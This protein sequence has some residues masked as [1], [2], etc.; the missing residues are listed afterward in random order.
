MVFSRPATGIGDRQAHDG[1]SPPSGPVR[2]RRARRGNPG[3]FFGRAGAI[4]SL[5]ISLCSRFGI[6]ML[7]HRL[8]TAIALEQALGLLLAGIAP[9]V[10]GM[11]SETAKSGAP[12][13]CPGP[14]PVVSLRGDRRVERW[15]WT[16]L[17]KQRNQGVRQY[18]GGADPLRVKGNVRLEVGVFFPDAGGHP[19][20]GGLPGAHD[21]DRWCTEAFPACGCAGW[22]APAARAMRP[23]LPLRG[24]GPRLSA[25]RA[26]GRPFHRTL[27]SVS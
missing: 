12:S 21:S 25:K 24:E 6:L 18:R 3:P 1:K 23:A 10:G 27:F 22:E 19:S 20:R 16:G 7:N 11:M 14:E 17:G 5:P 13:V 2:D 4:L 15:S 8:R 9:A 26:G